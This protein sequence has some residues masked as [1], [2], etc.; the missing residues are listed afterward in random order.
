MPLRYD[1]QKE[2]DFL[3]AMQT[4]SVTLADCNLQEFCLVAKS[5]KLQQ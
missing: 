1:Y 2:T 4:N 3:E 5:I